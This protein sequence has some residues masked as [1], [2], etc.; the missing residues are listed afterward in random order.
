MAN[1]INRDSRATAQ[2]SIT[3]I[4]HKIL[5]IRGERV[6]LDRDL[7]RLYGVENRVLGQA[8]KRNIRRFASD[9]MFQLSKEEFEH[10]KSQVVIS[11]AGDKMGLR[12]LPYALTEHRVAMLS[13][14]LRSEKALEVNIAIMRAFSKLRRI[15]TDNTE[16]AVKLNNLERKYDKQ[17]RVV[18][19]AIREHAS[20]HSL[21]ARVDRNNPKP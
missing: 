3:A 15:L 7:A 2:G 12:K 5:T 9:F 18:F 20:S 21:D 14:V 11:N 4:E 8:V 16:L 17:F 6:I 13:S 10:W 1:S 19:D